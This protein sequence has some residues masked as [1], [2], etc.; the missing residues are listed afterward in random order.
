MLNR[1]VL[2]TGPG[3]ETGAV[4]ASAQVDGKFRRV[5]RVVNAAG[6]ERI[7]CPAYR[8]RTYRLSNPHGRR[9]LSME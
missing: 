6:C 2:K 3:L 9:A 1:E 5:E 4:I 8:G 7:R